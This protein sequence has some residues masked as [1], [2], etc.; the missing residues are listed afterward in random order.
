MEEEV[1]KMQK[2]KLGLLEKWSKPEITIEEI[3]K[4]IQDTLKSIEELRNVEG[5]ERDVKYLNLKVQTL[6]EIK[7]VKSNVDKKIKETEQQK[8]EEEVEGPIEEQIE[9][10]VIE[11]ISK[12]EYK[13]L[14]QEIA[15]R[16]EAELKALKEKTDGDP[17][18]KEVAEINKKYDAEVDA[19]NKKEI[20]EVVQKPVTEEIIEQQESTEDVIVKSEFTEAE[21]TR[22]KN[23]LNI[24]DQNDISTEI[25]EVQQLSLEDIDGYYNSLEEEEAELRKKLE[26]EDDNCKT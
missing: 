15:E 20:E 17:S 24:N 23:E 1:K 5:A 4:E 22:L 9:E 11:R 12:N 3:D 8:A 13:E 16:R 25:S 6:E 10:E 18:Y 19:L 2:T 7:E 14:Y 26:K 21:E